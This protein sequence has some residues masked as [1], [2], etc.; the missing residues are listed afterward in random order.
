MAG[1]MCVLA[2]LSGRF[3]GRRGPRPSLL[4]GGVAML[5]GALMLTQLTPVTSTGLLMLSYLLFGAGSGLV[6]PPITNT[7]VSG[8]PPSQ[9]GV[10]AAIASTGRQVGMAL[11]VAIVGSAAGGGLGSAVGKGF[12]QA[13]H[14]GWW[15]IVALALMVLILGILTTTEWAKQTAQATAQRFSSPPTKLRASE[16]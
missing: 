4:F 12:A 10:A 11:G 7:A 6:N 14:A 5:L 13:T 8:K 2:P 3:V 1:M 9:A 15:I 16:T